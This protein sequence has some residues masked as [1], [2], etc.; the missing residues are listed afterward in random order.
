VTDGRVVRLIEAKARQ[1]LRLRD[2]RSYLYVGSDGLLRLNTGYFSQFGAGIEAAADSFRAG[3][4]EIEILINSSSLNRSEEVIE[5]L[6]RE[7]GLSGAGNILA[8]YEVAGE[9]RTA[10]V[11]LTPLSQ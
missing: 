2:V 6:V 1:A 11:I 9:I 4:L 7:M 10:R 5:S 3:T 8:T